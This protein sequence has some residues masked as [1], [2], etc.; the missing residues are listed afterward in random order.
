MELPTQ[1]VHCVA[2]ASSKN[3]VQASIQLSC[4]IDISKRNVEIA[5]KYIAVTPTWNIVDDLYIDITDDFGEKST[6]INFLTLDNFEKDYVLNSLRQQLDA[7]FQK[8]APIRLVK[9]PDRKNWVL[10]LQS[11]KS[12]S[13]SASLAKLLGTNKFYH[14]ES[15]D[16]IKIPI[17]FREQIVTTET[18]IYYLK[19][20]QIAS[21]F[22]LDG[23][24]D[25]ILEI[26]HI[27][28]TETLDFRPSLTYS[29]VEGFLLEK[30]I[31]TL[32]NGK[33]VVVESLLSDI[34][35]VC[36]IRPI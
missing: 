21:N 36:H 14:N 20:D 1:G 11:D 18:D 6:I 12:I 7:K 30:L 8:D 16:E 15:D 19:C 10:K 34:Y 9:T 27:P 24:Q 3:L 4:P 31:F 28:S 22:F 33:N 17:L 13:I 26:L 32:Y 29:T 25:R 2:K 35:I 23:K 5:V